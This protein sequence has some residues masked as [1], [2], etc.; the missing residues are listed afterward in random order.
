VFICETG[1]IFPKSRAE[2]EIPRAASIESWQKLQRNLHSSL[3]SEL[4]KNTI[5]AFCYYSTYERLSLL[6]NYRCAKFPAK[7]VY[8]DEKTFVLRTSYP[9]APTHVLIIPKKHIA[10]IDQATEADAE[11]IGY[12]QLVA[13]KIAKERKLEHGFRT[14]ITSGPGAG[15][16]VFPSSSAFAWRKEDELAAGIAFLQS[17]SAAR[18]PFSRAHCK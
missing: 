12:C 5:S 1:L 10:G 9:Q 16:T 4:E 2:L 14:F 17:R 8:E 7:K 3:G 15:K 11:L 13:A 6:Q 18:E